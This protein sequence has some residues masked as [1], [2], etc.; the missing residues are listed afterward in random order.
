MNKETLHKTLEQLRC[1]LDGL[2]PESGPVKDHIS[3]LVNDL[4]RQ[5][6]DL[7]NVG[8]RV[9]MRNRIAA[10]IERFE[11]EHPSIAG[12]LNQIVTTLANMGV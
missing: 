4:E 3:S 10:L 8:Q 9:A 1:E 11:L 6:Q 7:G 5:F 12:M 2:G